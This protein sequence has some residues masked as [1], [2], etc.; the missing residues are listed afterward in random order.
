MMANGS[1]IQIDSRQERE[2][3]A[4]EIILC[5]FITLETLTNGPCD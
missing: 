4:A 2:T 3:E 5:V 1:I